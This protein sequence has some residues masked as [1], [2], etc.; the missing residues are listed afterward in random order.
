MSTT[1][2]E[3]QLA[4]PRRRI[5]LLRAIAQL[6][7]APD[8]SRIQ[9]HLEA[10]RQQE[11]SVLA[12]AHSAPDEVDAKVG[13]LTTRLAVAERALAADVSDDWP[14]FATAV[15]SELRSWDTHL[16]RLQASVAAKAWKAREQ[17]EAAIGAVRTSRIAVYERL[18][19][20]RD[21]A[22]GEARRRVTAA[23]DELERKADELSA[24][25]T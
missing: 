24:H 12:A 20:E 9:R 21:G 4:G 6:E 17:A 1:T 3:G 10:V 14:S 8:R 23:R 25:L 16:E 13:Q 2:I 7:I 5:A 18:T 19:Q 22:A 11:A 15:E